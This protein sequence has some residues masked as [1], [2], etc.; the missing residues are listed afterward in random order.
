[1]IPDVFNSRT[2]ARESLNADHVEHWPIEGGHAYLVCDGIDHIEHTATIVRSFSRQLKAADWAY[3][4]SPEAQL[5]RNV[6]AIM[7]TISQNDK[8]T[9]F[10]LSIALDADISRAVK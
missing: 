5:A 2:G 3:S 7:D 1:M 10:C 9:A 8:G 6:L 4:E